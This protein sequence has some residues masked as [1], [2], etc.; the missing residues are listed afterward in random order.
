MQKI[1]AKPVSLHYTQKKHI[2]IILSN[3]FEN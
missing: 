1:N 2:Q 3:V